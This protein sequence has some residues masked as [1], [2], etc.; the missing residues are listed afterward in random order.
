MTDPNAARS[1]TGPGLSRVPSPAAAL[2]ENQVISISSGKGGVG[3]TWFAVTLCHALARRS[4]RALLFDAD[5][6]LANADIQLGLMPKYDLGSV[7]EGR[8]SLDGAI[9]RCAD[10]DFDVIAGRSGSGALAAISPTRLINLRE[11]LHACA[12]QYDFTV[13][14]VGAGLDR[15]VQT[16]AAGAGTSLVVTTDEPTSLT[17]AYAFIKVM[18]A[19][20][21]ARTIQIV[22]NMAADPRQGEHTYQTL[23]KACRQFL[24][25]CP[26]LAGII[27]RDGHVADAIR[28]QVPLLTRH[29]NSPAA[30]DV[31]RLAGK[32]AEHQ[33]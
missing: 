16:M 32:I 28:R 31:E 4:R 21:H 20:G 2:K 19:A 27:R 25:L 24:K 26:P 5:L 13:I 12:K 23:A 22:V 33:P 18:S 17:D 8:R 29:P 11:Q 7:L 6:G 9:T 10:G 15:T 14:D 3:K 30:E 1:L